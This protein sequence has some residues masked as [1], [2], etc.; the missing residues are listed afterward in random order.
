MHKIITITTTVIAIMMINIASAVPPPEAVMDLDPDPSEG[1]LAGTPVMLS[2][3]NSLE[4][5][6]YEHKCIWGINGEAVSTQCSFVRPFKEGDYNVS[7][8]VETGP[9]GSY[10]ND[11]IS[12]DFYVY[13]NPAPE[14]EGVMK[15]SDPFS[16]SE[17]ESE[18]ELT[19]PLFAS[20]QII[21]WNKE[22]AEKDDE[23]TFSVKV[24][25]VGLETGEIEEDG[26]NTT[27]S[28]FAAKQGTYDVLVT[29]TDEAGQASSVNFGVKVQG[30]KD[31]EIEYDPDYVSEGSDIKF[32]LKHPCH[33]DVC[34]YTTSVIDIERGHTDSA[35]GVEFTWSFDDEGPYN[36]TTNVTY[37][38]SVIATGTTEFLVDDTIDDPPLII[39]NRT[40]PAVAG[41][42]VNISLWTYDDGRQVSFIDVKIYGDYNDETRYTTGRVIGDKGNITF[43]PRRAATYKVVAKACD[44][45]QCPEKTYSFEV[46]EK[47]S[48]KEVEQ[49]D[50]K[51]GISP[52]EE[53]IS[54][55]ETETQEEG[56]KETPGFGFLSAMLVLAILI[57]IMSF[58]RM[59]R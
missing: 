3:N 44:K 49:Q 16:D 51:E 11:L 46:L 34:K 37:N 14:I 58:R 7:L 35:E 31:L 9:G 56:K 39:I 54:E 33:D 30:S 8:Y 18:R 48:E 41:E 6:D 38:G 43:I 22:E 40:T 25:P 57:L 1:I 13:K 53:N 21:V 29:A 12:R 15:Y 47:P 5:F 19:V 32:R 50:Q 2:A 27:F 42:P 52:V 23:T 24:S 26:D 17:K 10:G 55:E 59:R 4:V 36:V 28:L 20:V 45:K